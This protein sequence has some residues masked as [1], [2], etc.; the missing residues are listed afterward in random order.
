MPKC[1]HRWQRVPHLGKFKFKCDWCEL[2]GFCTEWGPRGQVV[3]HS[4]EV[5]EDLMEQYTQLTQRREGKIP[6]PRSSVYAPPL[7]YV[8]PRVRSHESP[9]ED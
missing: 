4:K 6:P 9:H 2:F 1:T 3:P 8:F 7:P 5:S